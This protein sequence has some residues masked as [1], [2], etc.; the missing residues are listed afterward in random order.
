MT[1]RKLSLRQVAHIRRLYAAGHQTMAVIAAKY[2]VLPSAI[3]KVIRGINGGT[4]PAAVAARTKPP[5][6]QWT[7]ADIVLLVEHA[8]QPIAAQAEALGRSE[9]AVLTMRARLG[10][11]RGRE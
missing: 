10:L 9:S 4:V 2:N 6:R 1:A 8:D 3:Q 5:S 7:A 11:R